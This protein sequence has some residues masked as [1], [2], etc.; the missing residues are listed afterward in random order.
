MKLKLA[1]PSWWILLPWFLRIPY[2]AKFN[3]IIWIYWKADYVLHREIAFHPEIRAFIKTFWQIH[4]IN[5]SHIW[6]SPA[7]SVSSLRNIS[8]YCWRAVYI[9]FLYTCAALIGCF[10]ALN[11]FRIEYIEYTFYLSFEKW[12]V[13]TDMSSNVCKYDWH[14]FMIHVNIMFKV[15]LMHLNSNDPSSVQVMR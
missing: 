3:C 4:V 6:H 11:L 1:L 15:C 8:N 14:I 7:L 9:F 13:C 10:A 5:Y 12:L 2:C